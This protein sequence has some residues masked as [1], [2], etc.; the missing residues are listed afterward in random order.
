MILQRL[1]SVEHFLYI[2]HAKSDFQ[3]VEMLEDI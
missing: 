1:N 3:P 2:F